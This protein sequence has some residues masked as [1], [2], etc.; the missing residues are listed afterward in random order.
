MRIIKNWENPIKKCNDLGII[1]DLS[2]LNEAGFWDVEKLS[3]KP[4]VAT[5]SNV[6]KLCES[7]RN[8]TDN[9]LNAIAESKGMV[10]LNFATGFLR[11]DG[12][13][14]QTQMVMFLLDI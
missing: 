4:L 12:K 6:H 7:P 11:S 10:G 8:L 1:I 13:K 14:D 9:Q 2:H 5:H 3:S